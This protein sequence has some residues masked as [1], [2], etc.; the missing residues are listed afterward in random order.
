MPSPYEGSPE[1]EWKNITQRL[2]EAH[3]LQISQI[4]DVALLSWQNLW[5]T[6]IGSGKTSISIREA[7]P[8]ATVIGYFF[9]RLFARQ[10]EIATSGAWR[11]GRGND[12]DLVFESDQAF[13]IEMKGSGQLGLKIF[14]NRSY[15]QALSSSDLAKKDKSGYYITFNFFGD[16]LCLLRFGWIDGTDWQA[17]AS[18]T[19]QMAGLP[20]RVYQHKLVPIK[21][22]YARCAP[23]A[24]LPGIGPAKAQALQLMDIISVNDVLS[25]RSELA[26]P[27]NSVVSAAETYVELYCH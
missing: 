9:E 8:P 23:A 7:N 13:S 16:I 1:T 19:G 12:K 17:Q 26:R 2:I 11:G 4:R 6:R 21:G 25:R 22:E 27:M 5:D 24:L 20:L 18:A 3:P 14:G 15:G 10:L